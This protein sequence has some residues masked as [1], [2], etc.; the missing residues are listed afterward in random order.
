MYVSDDFLTV[1]LFLLPSPIVIII[2][3]VVVLVLGLFSKRDSRVVKSPATPE[4]EHDFE[5][6]DD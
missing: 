2:V 3:V 4:Y 5:F 6:E 1:C